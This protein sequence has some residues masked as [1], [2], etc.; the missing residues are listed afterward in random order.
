MLHSATDE[1]DV[2]A[3]HRPLG[4]SSRDGIN[5]TE[6][7]PDIADDRLLSRMVWQQDEWLG[8]CQD[9]RT[10][11]VGRMS[12]VSS[13]DGR[14]FKELVPEVLTGNG[15]YGPSIVF[16]KKDGGF[17]L[18]AHS[19][20]PDEPR[21]FTVLGSAEPPYRKWK[22]KELEMVLVGPTMIQLPDGRLLVAGRKTDHTTFPDLSQITLWSLN[23]ESAK[24]TELLVLRSGTDLFTCGS[25]GLA[26]HDGHVWISYNSSH[27][28]NHSK[29]DTVIYLAKVRITEAA[30][31][32]ERRTKR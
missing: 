17:C 14:T 26:W 16:T 7:K 11:V 13:S 6:T 1:G 10:Q 5:W 24:F 3:K 28:L 12:L 19:Q 2:T 31:G 23:P 9:S 30:D 32:E 29:S 8:L 22:W 21:R 27:E 25:P 15:Y 18:A 4:W 20:T